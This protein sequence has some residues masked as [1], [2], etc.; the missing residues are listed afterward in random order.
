M[1][2]ELQEQQCRELLTTTTVGRIGFVAD[3]RVQIFPVNYAVSGNDL[4]I[5]TSSDG[6]LRR[7]GDASSLVAFEIDFH[8]DLAG[9]GWSV[10]MHGRIS[11]MSD[12]EASSITGREPWA[13]SERVLP[14]R[15]RIE[16]MSGRRVRRDL[17]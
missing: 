10:L 11:T 2:S 13:G 9:T 4:F 1:I 16:S 12:E 17:H 14:L 15:F 7:A 5:R 3:E 6:L 8:D